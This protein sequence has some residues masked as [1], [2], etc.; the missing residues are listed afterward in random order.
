MVYVVFWFFRCFITCL[1]VNVFM[2]RSAV[3]SY[4]R[5]E[6]HVECGTL[7]VFIPE[8]RHVSVDKTQLKARIRK[9]QPVS[10][11]GIVNI[12]PIITFEQIFRVTGETPSLILDRDA[13]HVFANL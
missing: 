13:Y 8:C 4:N 11:N 6:F 10:G 7:S 9:P 1:P 3:I 2:D 12:V 5:G